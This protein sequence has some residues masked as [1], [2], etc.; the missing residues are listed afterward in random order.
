MAGL[1]T[2]IGSANVKIYVSTSAPSDNTATNV[3]AL[4]T[5]AN[6]INDITDLPSI[7]ADPNTL[8]YTIFGSQS[9]RSVAGVDTATQMIISGEAKSTATAKSIAK[10]LVAAKKDAALH[11]V[12]VL[13]DGATTAK[14]TY[15]YIP[16]KKISH[17]LVPSAGDVTKWE[18][19]LGTAGD[20]VIVDKA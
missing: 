20:M 3:A 13:S 16:V 11:L 7:G 4:A 2:A 14:I 9:G 15:V 1:A 19:A 10:A 17:K 5:T 6:E 18:V 8:T 12:V